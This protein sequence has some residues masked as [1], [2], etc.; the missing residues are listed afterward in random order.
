ML[1]FLK[2]F[3]FYLPTEEDLIGADLQRQ[4]EVKELA[5]FWKL[6]PVVLSRATPA[7]KLQ[8]LGCHQYIVKDTMLPASWDDA[9]NMVS[10]DHLPSS[11]FYKFCR[12]I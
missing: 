2:R 7:S 5:L 11:S 9:D 12:C 4:E 10:R 8:D 3:Y 6:L 1:I